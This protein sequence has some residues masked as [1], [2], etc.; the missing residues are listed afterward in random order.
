MVCLAYHEVEAAD[1]LSVKEDVESNQSQ[2]SVSNNGVTEHER[3][4]TGHKDTRQRD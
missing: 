2:H 3:A 1:E 4:C